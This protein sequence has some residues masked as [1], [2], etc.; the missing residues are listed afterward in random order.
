MS[1]VPHPLRVH[2]CAGKD[3]PIVVCLSSSCPPQQCTLLLL[4]GQ[5]PPRFPQLWHSA[6]Q[7]MVFGFPAHGTPLPSPLDCFY[8]A[9]PSPLPGTDL[10][11]LSLSI[12]CL[13]EHPRLWCLGRWYRW[14]VELSLCFV[15]LSPAAALFSATLRSFHLGRSPHWLDGFPGC[16]FLFS[17]TDPS[18]EC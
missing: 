17:L 12:Q 1:E 15:L 16:G 11:S 6:P 10:W 3:I 14:S 5:P 7:P 2:A 18:Q 13:P 9:N 4:Q 8:I